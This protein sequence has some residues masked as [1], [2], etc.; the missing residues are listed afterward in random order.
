M[1]MLTAIALLSLSYQVAATEPKIDKVEM[2][3]VRA[4]MLTSKWSGM[5]GMYGSMVQFQDNTKMPG[6][7]EFLERYIK[8]ELARL[9]MSFVE[10]ARSC[11]SAVE[12]YDSYYNMKTD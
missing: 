5:C 3:I 4:L 7:D 10:F 6:G 9:D 2:K 1:K 12:T 11:K 8:T